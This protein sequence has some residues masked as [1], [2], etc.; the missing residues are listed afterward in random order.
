MNFKTYHRIEEAWRDYFPTAGDALDKS[1]D[2]FWKK[3]EKE[4]GKEAADADRADARETW[5]ATKDEVKQGAAATWRGTQK[6]G[7][8]TGKG[9]S[10]IARGAKAVAT[11][12][13]APEYENMFGSPSPS[14][15]APAGDILSGKTM[16]EIQQKVLAWRTK[17]I[18][19]KDRTPAALKA[20]Q[21]LK[22]ISGDEPGATAREI[23][24]LDDGKF[25]DSGYILP[26]HTEPKVFDHI[27]H[28]ANTVLDSMLSYAQKGY[29]LKDILRF[30]RFDKGALDL[31]KKHGYL[32]T[33]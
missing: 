9:V 3:Y 5:D 32:Y 29:P 4:Y 14:S 1:K 30:L 20:E 24:F 11:A 15:S 28:Y 21:E 16:G 12:G 26:G 6:A 17:N 2:A 10:A 18:T 23:K 19:D 13:Y 27:G 7:K 8:L 22:S 25:I 31:L 33:G